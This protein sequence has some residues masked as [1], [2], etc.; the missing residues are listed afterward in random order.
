[1]DVSM[2]K[3]YRRKDITT[4]ST[5]G[6]RNI[7]K[8][9]FRQCFATTELGRERKLNIHRNAFSYNFKVGKR[10]IGYSRTNFVHHL[11]GYV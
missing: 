7:L 1:M 3:V 11:F 4:C 2:S 10:M 5:S 8:M 6:T 9:I